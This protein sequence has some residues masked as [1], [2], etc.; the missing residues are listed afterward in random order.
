MVYEYSDLAENS[1]E[2]EN[3]D[4]PECESDRT[5]YSNC[6]DGIEIRKCHDCGSYFEVEQE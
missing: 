6:A 2:V 4:C 3:T 1:K 5:S